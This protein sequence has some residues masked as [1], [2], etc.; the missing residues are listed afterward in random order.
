MHRNLPVFSTSKGN[1]KM[2]PTIRKQ[3]GPLGPQVA[4]GHLVMWEGALLQSP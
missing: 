3:L 1:R 2:D 4:Q